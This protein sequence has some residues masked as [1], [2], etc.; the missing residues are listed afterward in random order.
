[1]SKD[2]IKVA[3]LDR[4]G[5]INKEINYLYKIE[6]FEYTENCIEGLKKIRELGYEIIIVTNQAGI[7]RGY[8]SVEDYEILTDWYLNDLAK[9]G[10]KILDV[11]FCPHHPKGAVQKYA[12]LC[13]CRKPNVGMLKSI[14]EEIN[15]DF[16]NSILIGDKITDIQMGQSMGLNKKK[17]FLVKTGHSLPPKISGCR[18]FDCLYS[19]AQLLE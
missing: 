8:Y 9:K 11:K 13:D 2:K 14:F 6:D 4:D 5:V 15:I 12:I 18:V 7:A 17:L 19:V 1:M 16:A 10:I 3:F